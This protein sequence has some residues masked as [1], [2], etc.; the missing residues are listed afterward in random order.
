[1]AQTGIPEP[2]YK[3]VMCLGCACLKAR[4]ARSTQPLPR[5]RQST[6]LWIHLRLAAAGVDRQGSA[7]TKVTKFE[8]RSHEWPHDQP[9]AGALLHFCRLPIR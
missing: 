4:R 2:A 7:P 3:S 5:C 1:M 8:T 6:F 9:R